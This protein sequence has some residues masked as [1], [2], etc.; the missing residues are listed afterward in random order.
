MRT[1]DYERRAWQRFK[2]ISDETDARICRALT[3]GIARL[4]RE[5]N[6]YRL[7]KQRHTPIK[8]PRKRERRGDD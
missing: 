4:Q 8:K 2:R 6:E 5:A 1:R 7:W 3:D